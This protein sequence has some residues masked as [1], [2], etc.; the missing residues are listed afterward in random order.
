MKFDAS[1]GNVGIGNT[2]PDR[3]LYVDANANNWTATFRNVHAS[4]YGI[5]VDLSQS[6]ASN[7]YALA[8]YTPSNSG[9][10][11]NNHGDVNIGNSTAPGVPLM[12]NANNTG[13]IGRF[14][15]RSSGTQGITIG[16]TTGDSAGYGLHVGHQG[17][18]GFLHPYNYGSGGFTQMQIQA[19]DTIVNNAS[20]TE[21]LNIRPGGQ[22]L[23]GV[24]GNNF[25]LSDSNWNTFGRLK[26]AQ[27]G[28]IRIVLTCGHNS[29]GSS[30]EI[31]NDTYAYGVSAGT[32]VNIGSSS[33]TNTYHVSLRK[34]KRV[35]G[36]YA[37]GDGGWEYQIQRQNAYTFTV[38][39][40]VMG[41]GSDWT[42]TV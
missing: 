17:T 37:S 34:V 42:W 30:A 33:P 6:T 4:A 5:G 23:G 18:F 41:V 38:F 31:L 28:P 12:V 35:G 25:G 19:T 1:S 29:Y 39:M 13:K 16:T 7:L 26:N 11:V 9:M 22:I 24:A 8:V 14:V 27:G 21:V 40:T 10:F 3:R 32:V 15:N 36:D 20:G 2:N